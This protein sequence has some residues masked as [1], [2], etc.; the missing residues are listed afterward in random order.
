MQQRN[1]FFAADRF[2]FSLR[3][4]GDERAVG[5][6]GGFGFSE[7][8]NPVVD[9]LFEFVFVDEAVDLDGAEEVADAFADAMGRLRSFL[10]RMIMTVRAVAFYCGLIA[11]KAI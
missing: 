9:L 11:C 2:G 4:A 6:G 8:V 7:D 3:V 1:S 10:P 5:A